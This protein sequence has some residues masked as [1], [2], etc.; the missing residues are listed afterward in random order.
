MKADHGQGRWRLKGRGRRLKC[1]MK[2]VLHSVK[3]FDRYHK[4]GQ[5]CR[6]CG[7]VPELSPEY[8]VI[9]HFRFIQW[10]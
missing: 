4:F 10:Q 6:I 9:E 2:F 1:D 5:Q 3:E 8:G 7:F